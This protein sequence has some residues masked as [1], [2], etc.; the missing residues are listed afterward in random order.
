MASSLMSPC[1]AFVSCYAVVGHVHNWSC[2]AL[3][4]KK[5]RKNNKQREKDI[6]SSLIEERVCLD[7]LL[8]LRLE[9]KMVNEPGRHPYPIFK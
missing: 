1:F 4:T 2:L 9:N 6:H 8:L 7:A 5:K 3:H